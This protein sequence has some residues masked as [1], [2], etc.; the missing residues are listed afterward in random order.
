MK[1]Y[2]DH[3]ATTPVCDEAL[4]EME[5]CLSMFHGNAS[6]LHAAGARAR[7]RIENA[8]GIIA[9][10]IG[11]KP[12]EI[13]F[14]SG[15]TESNNAAIF[16]GSARSLCV[17]AVEHKSV[18]RAL[19][20][21]I[22]GASRYIAPVDADGLVDLGAVEDSIESSGKDCLVSIMHANNE[23]GVIQPILEIS[24]IVRDHRG[25][26]LHVDA[27]QSFGKIPVNVDDLGVD[28]MTISA[29]K[30]G[31]PKGVGALYIRSGV[32]FYPFIVGGHQESDRRGGTENVAGI[33]GFGAAAA[34]RCGNLTDYAL[35]TK[36]HRFGLLH[37]LREG[38]DGI[39]LN[40]G[41]VERIPNTL[42]VGFAGVQS[43][44]LVMMLSERGIY[45]SNGSACESGSILGSHV[46]KAMGQS[47]EESESAIRFSF[48]MDLEEGA[49]PFI[50]ENVIEC[51][52]SLRSMADVPF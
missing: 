7:E 10:L 43:E 21:S 33:A 4:D 39:H 26:L 14:T 15:G 18:L 38:L 16:A 12:K 17:S 41:H 22:V 23:T 52:M 8:R 49:V 48:G 31:G 24:D 11:A 51:V 46:L 45:V 30:I 36:A 25:C 28:M 6:S 44:A 40:G 1:Y 13:V 3:N 2:L 37:Y 27:C 35:T 34:A 5:V 50:A 9:R 47:E 32:G 42:N 29:H 19:E 20:R